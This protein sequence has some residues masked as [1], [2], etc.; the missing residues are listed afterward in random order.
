MAW[1]KSV[2]LRAVPGDS[3]WTDAFLDRMRAFGDPVADIPVAGVLN[4]G[5]VDHVNELMRSLV[6]VDQPLPE[7]LPAE[8]KAYLTTTLPMPSWADPA[9]IDRGQR[10]FE[11]W[12]VQISV[13]LFCASLPSAYAAAKGVKVLRRTGRLEDVHDARR[14]VVETG[15]FLMDVCSTGGLGPNGTG[16]RTIQRVRLMHGAIRHLILSQ[17]PT[18]PGLWSPADGKPIN[19][20]DL[21]GTLLSFSYVVG[22][23]LR[24]LGVPVSDDDAEAYIHLWNVIGDLLGLREDLMARDLDDATALVD[25]IRRRQFAASEDG[26]FMAAALIELLKELTPLKRFDGYSP[27]LMR[28]LLD[29]DVADMLAVPPSELADNLTA[30][31]KAWTWAQTKLLRRSQRE[32]VDAII[33]FL[34]K[35]FGKTFMHALFDYQRGNERPNFNIPSHL[36]KRWRVA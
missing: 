19:Q 16:R 3:R 7:A 27:A 14:R 31:R 34:A 15:Q 8:V 10:F 35:P 6:R 33:S 36:A 5:G 9:K 28:F 26:Q 29:K 20:E 30:L 18:V 2:R 25:A 4:S 11:K 21:A 1:A 32:A 12:G 17:A 22:D 24:R 13:C 23:P